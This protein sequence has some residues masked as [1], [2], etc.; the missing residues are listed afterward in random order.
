MLLMAAALL[1][2]LVEV[3]EY[4]GNSSFSHFSCC[5]CCCCF[6]FLIDFVLLLKV[7]LLLRGLC[8]D[9]SGRIY[10]FIK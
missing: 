4:N 9:F 3:W 7:P 10:Y 2:L 8:P 1:L 6:E 5:S